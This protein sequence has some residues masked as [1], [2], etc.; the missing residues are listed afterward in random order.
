MPKRCIVEQQ[1][2]GNLKKK[3]H[4][5]GTAG[6]TARQ[7]PG[8]C[9]ETHQCQAPRQ[10]GH[11]GRRRDAERRR[12]A[13][14]QLQGQTHPN[15]GDDWATREHFYYASL[16]QFLPGL[17]TTILLGLAVAVARAGS[18]GPINLPSPGPVLGGAR[19]AAILSARRP[20][21]FAKLAPSAVTL[22]ETMAG[23]WESR[24]SGWGA[25]SVWGGPLI[26]CE[27]GLG[28]R[29]NKGCVRIV[30]GWQNL[31]IFLASFV[32]FRS[33]RRLAPRAM[34][35]PYPLAPEAPF[36]PRPACSKKNNCSLKYPHRQRQ[37]V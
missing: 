27:R 22:R 36:Y 1:A 3:Q 17:A 34:V 23:R 9:L 30:S 29:A 31:L 18:R 26:A 20:S 7:M 14:R 28:R 37:I 13:V 6:A 19:G 15:N 24:Q 33:R 4:W 35:S 16:R 11:R 25:K 21:A 2:T 5:A 12:P 8:K 32:P 10:T